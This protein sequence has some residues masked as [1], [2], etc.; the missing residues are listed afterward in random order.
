MSSGLRPTHSEPLKSSA[1]LTDMPPRSSVSLRRT[2]D[3][4]LQM[5]TPSAVG[6]TTGIRPRKAGGRSCSGRGS[7]GDDLGI[8]SMPP[9]R[10]VS[11]V[12]ETSL[13]AVKVVGV[14]IPWFGSRA[15]PRRKLERRMQWEDHEHYLAGLTDILG[16]ESAKRL[17]VTGDFNQTI[18]PG[19]RA[20]LELQWALQN[21]FPSSM[22]IATSD[23]AFEGRREHRSYCSW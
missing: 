13:G 2:S 22:R 16:R 18:G 14:C 20:P 10:F 19:S 9:G 6:P 8:D 23:I 11:G 4:Y 12:T 21:A 3:C 17:I 15:E 5:D 7:L 1:A